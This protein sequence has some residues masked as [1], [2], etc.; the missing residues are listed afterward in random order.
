[1]LVLGPNDTD[2][3]YYRKKTYTQAQGKQKL[4]PLTA[5]RILVDCAENIPGRSVH[6]IPLGVYHTG[7]LNALIRIF[8]IS[9]R[10]QWWMIMIDLQKC[11]Y[12]SFAV[13]QCHDWFGCSVLAHWISKQLLQNCSHANAK[14]RYMLS[15]L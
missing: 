3:K 2:R 9:G 15:K 5:N 6:H 4:S 10:S 8:D 1:M 13:R 12:I 14:I 7:G 11:D